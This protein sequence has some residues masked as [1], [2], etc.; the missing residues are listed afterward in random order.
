ME[1]YKSRI[2]LGLT[3]WGYPRRTK[4]KNLTW[5]FNWSLRQAVNNLENGCGSVSSRFLARKQKCIFLVEN[6]QKETN[7]NRGVSVD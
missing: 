6:K 1:G 2:G 7:N 3:G 5:L 4:S